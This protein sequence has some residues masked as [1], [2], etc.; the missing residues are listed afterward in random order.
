MIKTYVIMTNRPPVRVSDETWP[1]VASGAASHDDSGGRGNQPN[2]ERTNW[3]RVRRHADGRH[4][5]YG[6][7]DYTTRFQGESGYSYSG[8]ELLDAG[9]DP[10]PVIHRVAH[11]IMARGG[12]DA[13]TEAAHACIADLPAEDLG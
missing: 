7:S 9:A 5:V 2:R 3:I 11:G 6:V 10:I 12:D 13:M 8:G 4:L 1:I